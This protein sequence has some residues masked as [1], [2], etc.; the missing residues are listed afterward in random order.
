M[1]QIS[2]IAAVDKNWGIGHE[3]CLLFHLKKDMA[4]FREKTVGNIVVM[5]RKTLESFPGGKPLPERRNLVLTHKRR[6][7]A[8]KDGEQESLFFVHSVEQA[9]KRAEEM[10]GQIYVIGGGQVYREFLPLASD[11]YITRVDA[12]R[13]ADT[14]FPNLDEEKEWHP[15]SFSECFFEKETG[16]QFIHYRRTNEG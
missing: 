7:K 3:N 16:F 9:V 12:V 5:G 2:M 8:A 14:F 13:E 10:Q 1:K 4:F 6:E 15:V 11:V